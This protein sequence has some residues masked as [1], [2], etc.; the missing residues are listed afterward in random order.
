[1]HAR[2]YLPFVFVFI[3]GCGTTDDAPTSSR[4]D[5]TSVQMD[6]PAAENSVDGDREEAME[7]GLSIIQSYFDG[8]PEVFVELIADSLPQIG[9]S[10]LPMSGD[11]FKELIATNVPYPA[12]TDLTGYTM[13]D[14]HAVFEPVVVTFQEAV[15][16]L[17]YPDV[18]NGGWIPA[19][20]E[21]IYLGV[22]LKAG[23]QESD[24][25]IRNGL[26]AFVFG[27]RDGEWKFVGFVF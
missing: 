1:M 24:R 16:D 15:Q 26:N 22:E 23:K 12:G 2:L 3:F 21:Y 20:D 25:F 4:N 6:S 14:Y 7:L 11:Q 5:N 18:T 9:G 19:D 13:E 8:E 27:K 17:G 10:G